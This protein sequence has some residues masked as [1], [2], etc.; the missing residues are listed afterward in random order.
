MN[1]HYTNRAIMAGTI[2]IVIETKSF[3]TELMIEVTFMIGKPKANSVQF[4]RKC[5]PIK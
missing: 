3:H 1:A 4:I 2:D 5:N